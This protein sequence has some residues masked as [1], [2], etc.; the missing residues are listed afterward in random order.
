M[1]ELNAKETAYRLHKSGFQVRKYEELQAIRNERLK[2]FEEIGIPALI[3]AE[4]ELIEFG[5]RVIG[6]M[7]LLNLLKFMSENNLEDGDMEND[8]K[9]TDL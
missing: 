5:E 4:K 8:N 6:G 3:Q 9:P 7:K 2:R 1:K